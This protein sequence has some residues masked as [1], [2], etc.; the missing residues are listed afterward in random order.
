ME[1]HAHTHSLHFTLCL[2][3][4]FAIFPQEIFSFFLR[5]QN[6]YLHIART[7]RTEKKF[8]IFFFW[9]LGKRKSRR[10]NVFFLVVWT[11]YYSIDRHP[12]CTT[13]EFNDFGHDWEEPSTIFVSA[14]KNNVLNDFL[15]CVLC[16]C[17][18]TN[19]CM[20]GCMGNIGKRRQIL[21]RVRMI[22]RNGAIDAWL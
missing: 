19:V 17:I 9:K 12:L 16:V 3:N 13:T 1:Q 5:F 20:S 10:K 2:F 18:G 4:I 11:E 6:K 21:F 14:A 7:H 8:G 15:V 22:H